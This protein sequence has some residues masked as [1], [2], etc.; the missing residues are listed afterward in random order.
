MECMFQKS[1]HEDVT[2]VV[3]GVVGQRGRHIGVSMSVCEIG[4]QPKGVIFEKSSSLHC[5]NLLEVYYVT[6]QIHTDTHIRAHLTHT[7]LLTER[8]FPLNL[9]RGSLGKRAI[10]LCNWAEE[11]KKNRENR[12][13]ETY[14]RGKVDTGVL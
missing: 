10:C 3:C 11:E 8:K 7:T 9:C 4:A 12:E 14:G 13:G 5:S 1:R 6:G 2:V